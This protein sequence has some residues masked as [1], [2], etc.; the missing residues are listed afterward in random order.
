M[1]V[2][3]ELRERLIDA[4]PIPHLPRVDRL[5]L[6]HTPVVDHLRKERGGDANVLRSLRAV[7]PA[8]REGT[9]EDGDALAHDIKGA[10]P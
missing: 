10:R 9:G 3:G 5:R 7:Q 6:R 4:Q 2:A 8:R 1:S